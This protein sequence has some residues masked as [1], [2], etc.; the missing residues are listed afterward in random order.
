MSQSVKPRIVS[1]LSS[2]WK[3]EAG[4]VVLLPAFAWFLLYQAGAKPDLPVILAMFASSALLVIGAACWR[5]ELARAQGEAA[6]ADRIVAV[7]ARTEQL[8]FVLAL[9]GAFAALWGLWRAGGLTPA[10]IAALALGLLAVLEYLNYYVV[11]LQHFDHVADFKRLL[12]GKGF[13]RPHLAKAIARHKTSL[14]R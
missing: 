12:S 4:N 5:M 10:A 1:R 6:L 2:Y 8:G 9:L 11:Q 14:R 3:L 13:R 7:L